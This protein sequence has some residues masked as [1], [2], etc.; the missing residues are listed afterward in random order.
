LYAGLLGALFLMTQ[1]LQTALGHSALGVALLAVVFNRPG[2]YSSPQR[3]IDGFSAALW[4]AVGLS[5]LGILAAALSPGRRPTRE[6][7][8][9]QQPAHAPSL[10]LSTENA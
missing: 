9:R 5:T 10:G 8:V 6:P 4:V 2:V 7:A 1:L 3:F